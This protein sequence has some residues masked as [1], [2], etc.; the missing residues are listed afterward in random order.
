M[1][2]DVFK[3]LPLQTQRSGGI[4]T[5]GVFGGST[6]TLTGMDIYAA[7][8]F[9]LVVY[10]MTEFQNQVSND[11]VRFRFSIRNLTITEVV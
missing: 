6:H 2:A 10:P 5:Q 3:H 7:E 1:L 4:K 8:I 11:G 9:I